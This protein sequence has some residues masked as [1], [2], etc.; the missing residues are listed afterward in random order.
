MLSYPLPSIKS[1]ISTHSV[2]VNSSLVTQRPC[3][4]TLLAVLAFCGRSWTRPERFSFSVVCSFREFSLRKRRALT[5]GNLR[6]SKVGLSFSVPR[7]PHCPWQPSLN[8]RALMKAWLAIRARVVHRMYSAVDSPRET[9]KETKEGKTHRERVR[10]SR[11]CGLWREKASAIIPFRARCLPLLS[12]DRDPK[13]FS[14]LQLRSCSSGS[15][16][17]VFEEILSKRDTKLPRVVQ[18]DQ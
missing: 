4:Q 10:H 1:C 18:N 12:T 13:E 16:S 3:A 9:E 8:L 17:S 5:V 11:R 14:M 15:C 6:Y 2:A 7:S